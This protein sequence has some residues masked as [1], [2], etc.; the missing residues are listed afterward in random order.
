MKQSVLSLI[1]ILFCS[2]LCSC[3]HNSQSAGNVASFSVIKV[4]RFLRMQTLQGEGFEV[5]GKKRREGTL[6][7]SDALEYKDR[8][9]E[10]T[11]IWRYDGPPVKN[12]PVVLNFDYQYPVEK[13]IYRIS[14]QYET[15]V[16]G[17]YTFKFRNTGDNYFER[18]EIE[19]WRVSI[20]YNDVQVGYKQS[21]FF[22]K[23]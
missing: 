3:A 13:T 8:G 5:I 23:N 14:E 15:I 22:G 4:N 20:F 1:I 21:K 11:V 7:L 12:A 9:E 17:R 19:S 18:G 2:M 6:G 16:P 10:I